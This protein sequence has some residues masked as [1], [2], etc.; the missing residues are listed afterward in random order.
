ML[1]QPGLARAL[2][3]LE[4]PKK[5]WI[6]LLNV[7]KVVTTRASKGPGKAGKALGGIERPY[8]GYN[9]IQNLPNVVTTRLARVLERLAF[10]QQ[11]LA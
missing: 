2:G 3:R 5:G 7:P 4:R 8:K 6:F 10:V 1:S 9:S 11:E